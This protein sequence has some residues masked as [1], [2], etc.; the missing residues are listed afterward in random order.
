MSTRAYAR[1]LGVA[2]IT[3]QTAYDQ[4]V[5]EGYLDVDGRRGTHVT[6]ALPERG[7]A[8]RLPP[9]WPLESVRDA[10][11]D[12]PP[13]LRLP[14]R[15][16]WAPLVPVTP[17]G[18]PFAAPIEL[19]PEWFGL[20]VLDRRAWERALVDAWRETST[21]PAGAIAT[22]SGALGDERLRA[23]LADHLAVRRGVRCR[24]D[25]I[26]I[27][28]GSSAVLA[29]VARVWLGPGRVCVVEDPGGGQLRRSLGSA[30]AEIVPVPVDKAGSWW[31]ACHRGPMSCS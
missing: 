24:P 27:T 1:E 31:I 6:Q 21:E 16:P 9:D 23:A 18:P 14:A 22:Y 12:A 25:M 7:F 11:S 13:D 10:R 17:S 15:N 3:I 26:A 2:R 5:A 30:G 19:G 29:A 4:L 8:A 20:D 28:A